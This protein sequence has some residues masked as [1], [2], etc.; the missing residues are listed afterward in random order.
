MLLNIYIKKKKFK[1][2]ILFFAMNNDFRDNVFQTKYE[3][4]F[5]HQIMIKIKNNQFLNQLLKVRFLFQSKND[6]KMNISEINKNY[7][8]I[9]FLKLL[10]NEKKFVNISKKET[11]I[12]FKNLKDLSLKN[13]AQLIIVGIPNISEVFK[14]IDKILD[15]KNE[16][17][18]EKLLIED[19]RKKVDFNNPKKVFFSVCEKA[20]IKCVYVPLDKKS[21]HEIDYGHWNSHGQEITKNYLIK[22][23]NMF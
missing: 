9:N 2:I 3:K 8:H 19:F 12:A 6:E 14:D 20:K 7:F 4:N 11:L 15:L 16:L 10:I 22:H 13:N 17:L 1:K 21:F 23:L 18:S 5:K